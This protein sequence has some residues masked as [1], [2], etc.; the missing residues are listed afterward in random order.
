MKAISN[1]WYMVILSKAKDQMFLN[2][3]AKRFFLT[4][5]VSRSFFST[6]WTLFW[7]SH[8]WLMNLKHPRRSKSSFGFLN[9]WLVF[10]NY[11]INITCYYAQPKRASLPAP[12]CPPLSPWVVPWTLPAPPGCRQPCTSLWQRSSPGW[13]TWMES[14]TEEKPQ[15]VFIDCCM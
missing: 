5:T 6:N 14:W 4:F 15:K 13:A 8:A 10:P 11:L 2:I 1:K 7:G 9:D 3:F 12:R